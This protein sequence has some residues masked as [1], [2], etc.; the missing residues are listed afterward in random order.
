MRKENRFLISANKMYSKNRNSIPF[1]WLSVGLLYVQQFK[2][3]YFN[4]DILYRYLSIELT[5][6]YRL[7]IAIVVNRRAQQTFSDLIWFVIFFF[8]LSLL[9]TS[10][11][12]NAQ[13]SHFCS[14]FILCLKCW[15][16]IKSVVSIILFSEVSIVRNNDVIVYFLRYECNYKVMLFVHRVFNTYRKL[17][18]GGFKNGILV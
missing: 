4:T 11:S 17:I 18:V 8:I 13:F 6:I 7:P 3:R 14:T 12:P 1:L 10:T 5:S 2:C 15:N 16:I 9:S